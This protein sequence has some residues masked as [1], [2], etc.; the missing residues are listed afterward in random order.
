MS[1]FARRE[2]GRLEAKDGIKEMKRKKSRNLHTSFP[3]NISFR[4]YG[5]SLNNSLDAHFALNFL[6]I[7][8]FKQKITWHVYGSRL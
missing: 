1:S 5:S 7:K 6:S 2:D 8:T 4:K 3:L